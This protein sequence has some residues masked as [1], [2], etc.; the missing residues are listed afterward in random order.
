VTKVFLVLYVF[1]DGNPPQL[2]S[3]A[4]AGVKNIEMASMAACEAERYKRAFYLPIGPYTIMY[5]CQEMV[6]S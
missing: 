4:D 3:Q 6:V 2:V 1:L 5:T